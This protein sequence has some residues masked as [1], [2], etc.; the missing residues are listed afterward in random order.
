MCVIE[1]IYYRACTPTA[2]RS[3]SELP[4]DQNVLERDRTEEEF[5]RW[6]MGSKT[7]RGSLEAGARNDLA[8]SAH[9][10]TLATRLMELGYTRQKIIGLNK[11]LFIFKVL[12]ALFATLYLRI[13]NPNK[14][15]IL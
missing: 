8:R 3:P 14:I 11:F 4:D 13:Y 2:A 6:W 5:R 15:R 10:D 9:R 12:D 7:Q 1:K